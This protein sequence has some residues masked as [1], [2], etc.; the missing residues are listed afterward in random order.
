MW[1]FGLSKYTLEGVALT[2][3]PLVLISLCFLK[4]KYIKDK[5]IIP[6]LVC[7]LIYLA[8]K[9]SRGEILFLLVLLGFPIARKLFNWSR[10]PALLI[11][12]FGY[13]Q[14]F[15]GNQA[16]N[17][18]RVLN[19]L[20]L[21]SFSLFGNGIGF[22]A[23]EILRLTNNDYSSF[24]NIHFELI[25][26]FGIWVYAGFLAFTAHYI[27]TGDYNRNRHYYLCLLFA[28]FATN[29]ELFDIYF[30]VPMGVVALEVLNS[31][32]SKPKATIPKK[33]EIES[34]ADV[35]Y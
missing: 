29:F 20:F 7:S 11:I 5:F 8:C 12:G 15:L 23:Q 30:A 13:F 24:H 17:G 35:V 9:S 32:K 21:N 33:P 26:N 2:V 22:S 31:Y 4:P 25:T 18:R 27:L 6:G 14:L 16:L 1:L 10:W 3:Y 19:D 34:V 28:L